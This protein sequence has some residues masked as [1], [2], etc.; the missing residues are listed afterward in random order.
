MTVS[1]SQRARG[2]EVRPAAVPAP[3]LGQWPEGWAPVFLVPLEGSP[4]GAAALTVA[5][6]LAQA[7]RSM[8]HLVHVTD[9]PLSESDLLR[10][11]G[12]AKAD[13]HGA[14]LDRLAGE[15][16]RA[17]V[18]AGR[19]MNAELIVMG[20]TASAEQQYRGIGPVSERVVLDGP[21]P[22]LLVRPGACGRLGQEAGKL[23]RVLL[24]LDGAPS[25]AEVIAPALALAASSGADLDVLHVAGPGVRR[26][27]EPG[28][29]GAPRYV[30]QPQ[31]EWPS[32]AREFLD[33]FCCVL[34]TCPANVP[35][36]L[37]LSMGAPGPAIIAFARE[38]GSDLIVLEWRGKVRLNHAGIVR[39]VVANALCP[40]LLI[41]AA[42]AHTTSPLSPPR[43]A[44]QE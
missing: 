18:A 17:I 44:Q 27:V 24:P 21:A 38:H 22:V 6:N 1:T 5:R 37:S 42:P 9:E 23:T 7:M 20:A 15:P 39:F 4:A 19:R 14:V 30:D 31:H 10:R 13:L 11:L 40:V 28:T 25:S 29:F 41:R 26:P 35:T 36:R 2:G 12:L 3:S 34:A 43:P 32:W 33:R 16:S 8:V